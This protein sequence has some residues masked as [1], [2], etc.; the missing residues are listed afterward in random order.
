MH[1]YHYDARTQT[2]YLASEIGRAGS[3]TALALYVATPPGR[4]LDNWTIRM[5]HTT[6]SAYSTASWETGWTPVYVYRSNQTVSGSG[7]RTFTLTAPFSYDGVSN[8]MIDFSHNG[9]TWASNGMC[10]YSTPGGNRSVYF[11]THSGYGDPLNWSGASNPT[12][13]VS[14]K[15]PNV[16]LTMDAPPDSPTN[17]AATPASVCV[18]GCSTLSATPGNG[19]DQVWWYTQSCGGTQVGTGPGNQ[20]VCPTSTTT[21]YARTK[22]SAT[23]CSGSGC[24][25]VTV[26]VVTEPADRTVSAQDDTVCSGGGTNIQITNSESAVSYQLRTVAGDPVGEPVIGDAS[27][28]NLPT[29]G[30]TAT[31]QFRVE[32]TRSPCSVV[33][34]TNHPTV[35]VNMPISITTQPT[36]QTKSLGE[37]VTFSVEAGGTPAPVFQ[38]R[39]DGSDILDATSSS[40]T[41][42]SVATC[43]A[44][45][46]GCVVTNTCGPVTSDVATLTISSASVATVPAARALSDG[47]AL[48]L[49]GPVVTRAFTSFFYVED[50]DRLSG[51]RVNQCGGDS[52]TEGSTPII[53]GTI[54]T[55]DGERAID[56]ARWTAN[57]SATI[58]GALGLNNRAAIEFL[59]SG[60]FIRLWGTTNVPVGATDTFTIS[61][62]SGTPIMVKVY[63]VSLPG[64]GVFVV[65]TGALGMDGS[66]P[67]LRVNSSSD[68]VTVP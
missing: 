4:T 16:R 50:L 20:T 47:A 49:S 23:G 1:T 27:T 62:G 9:S 61:D 37:T 41:I 55:I 31:T 10:R 59:P 42:N 29:G 17:P 54:Q 28:I 18:G 53:L 48:T 11:Y 15:V 46:Y 67:V 44:A 56:S 65:V 12:P 19:G 68:V 5:K 25:S 33:T 32:A 60:L 24:A 26:T 14:T 3:I 58:P 51:I 22:N 57:G 63:G 2:I 38:W 8:L 64:N 43:D 34:M 30:L 35:A 13:L 6:L 39:K 45:G 66:S 7:W 36:S 52:P 21:Y 40:Y